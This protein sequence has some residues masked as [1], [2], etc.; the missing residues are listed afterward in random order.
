MLYSNRKG[1]SIGNVIFNE[2]VVRVIIIIYYGNLMKIENV[3]KMKIIVIR[4][5]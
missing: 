5:F 1:G 2:I 4:C 3:V